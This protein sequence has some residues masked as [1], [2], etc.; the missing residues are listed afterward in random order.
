[1]H[2]RRASSGKSFFVGYILFPASP[3]TLAP[4]RTAIKPL[5]CFSVLGT[6]RRKISSCTESNWA[7]DMRHYSRGFTNFAKFAKS[8]YQ[9]ARWRGRRNRKNCGGGRGGRGEEHGRLTGGP[10]RLCWSGNRR[11]LS[12]NKATGRG[13]AGR[14]QTT[15]RTV[16]KGLQAMSETF[17]VLIVGV[18]HPAIL[19]NRRSLGYLPRP[20]LRGPQREALSM[21]VRWWT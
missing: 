11:R 1:M 19:A 12:P 16:V 2:F 10:S 20:G 6:I 18:V 9:A 14:A 3:G 17:D 8:A 4:T 13:S 15:A 7:D 21:A 5:R